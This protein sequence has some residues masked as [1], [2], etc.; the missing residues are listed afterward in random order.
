MLPSVMDLNQTGLMGHKSTDINLPRLFTNLH[1]HHINQGTRFIASL[2]IGKVFDT[3][4]PYLW[5]VFWRMGFPF[6]W[7]DIVFLHSDCTRGTR[8]GCL[9]SLHFLQ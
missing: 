2:G 9:F 1:A 4:W 5:K 8:K 3:E 6:T 7:K